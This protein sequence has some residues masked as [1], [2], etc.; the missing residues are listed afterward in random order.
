MGRHHTS[1]EDVNE[2]CFFN[3]TRKVRF[4][5]FL[6]TVQ[7]WKMLYREERIS[8]SPEI[9]ISRDGIELPSFITGNENCLSFQVG[10]NPD[11]F[12]TFLFRRR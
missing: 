5:L 7:T 8:A 3:L 12:V 9:K 11:L 10:R 4:A 6:E 2:P 1:I